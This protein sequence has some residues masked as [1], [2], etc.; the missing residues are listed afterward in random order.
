MNEQKKL[1]K[2]YLS[3]KK[4]VHNIIDSIS[5]IYV[6]DKTVLDLG[7]GIEQEM[8]VTSGIK[9]GYIC[10]TTLFKLVT[11]QI[12]K[13]IQ[14]GGRGFTNELVNIGVAY[15]SLQMMH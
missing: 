4:E 9:Q 11:Y 6:D 12:I 8:E 13:G 14:E 7:E 10:S 1:E 5:D 15:Y 2:K 3:K